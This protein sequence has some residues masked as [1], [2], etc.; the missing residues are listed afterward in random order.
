MQGSL[1]VLLQQ[2]QPIKG[3]SIEIDSIMLDRLD[4]IVATLS[5]LRT[6]FAQRHRFVFRALQQ[7]TNGSL[8][9]ASNSCTFRHFI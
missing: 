2:Q 9:V 6:D 1:L 3:Q 4:T 8:D 7:L 5:A